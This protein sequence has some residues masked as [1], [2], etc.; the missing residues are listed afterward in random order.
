M[1][2]L[3]IFC[4]VSSAMALSA[5]KACSR[6]SIGTGRRG[7]ANAQNAC[8]GDDPLWL[9]SPAGAR[10][11]ACG[12]MLAARG[13]RPALLLTILIP[14]GYVAFRR[15]VFVSNRCVEVRMGGRHALLSRG[16]LFGPIFH[17]HV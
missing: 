4:A 6:E 9:Q 3:K 17:D 10:P 1:C 15:A 5:A 14:C 11:D 13:L 16:A 2:S 8:D 7:W 12:P